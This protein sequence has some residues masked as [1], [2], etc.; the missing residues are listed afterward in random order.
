MEDD[1]AGVADERTD[2]GAD[3]GAARA[4]DGIQAAA[5]EV[6]E[7]GESGPHDGRRRQALLGGLWSATSQ[8][9]PAAGTAALS[10]VAAR[11]LGSDAL[12]TQS[13]IA[14]V[15]MATAAVLAA[16]LTSASLRTMG[17]LSGSGDRQRLGA[18]SRWA[19]GVH[20]AAGLVVGAIMATIGLV[21][22]RDQA[23][24]AVIGLVSVIDAAAMGVALP[25]VLRD[26]WATF[27]KL[28]LVFQLTAPPMGIAA[29]LLG[30]GITGIFVADGLAALGL[31][32]T[33]GIV[34]RGRRSPSRG[35]VVTGPTRVPS[36]GRVWGALRPPVPFAAT[37]FQFAMVELM[38]QVVS[39]R[40]EFVVLGWRSTS[41]Q[42]AM[43][44]VSFVVVGLLSVVPAAVAMAA[45]PLIAAAEGS[46]ALGAAARH[47]HVA[48]RLGTLVSLPLVAAVIALGP[49]TILLV[50]GDVYAEAAHLV[51]YAALALLA[52]VAS[53]VCTQFWLGQGKVRLV[54]W[55]GAA[56][57][58]IDIGLAIA[59]TP[60]MGAAGAVLANVVGQVSLA[61]LLLGVTVRRTGGFGWVPR[62]L[63][64]MVVVSAVAAA[65]ALL[66]VR[67]TT[68][69]GQQGSVATRLIA[70]VLAAILASLVGVGA[71]ALVKVLDPD[72]AD[73]L[74][75][76]LP[77]R[78]A[79]AVR[80][81]TRT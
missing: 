9:L 43:Y 3:P 44:S 38:V 27:G 48:V 70:L 76:L 34:L 7:V 73:W 32:V 21:L 57:G 62:N 12:G 49:T 71:A 5:V 75:P 55:C 29:V 77:R 19:T 81:V 46:G 80:A 11:Q 37:W 10:V 65:A 36:S 2:Q 53:G 26:G 20:V 28:S 63:A 18:M 56:A 47:L 1:D 13:L 45:M 54:L 17:R 31:L 24:W 78:L 22:H 52:T 41:E 79:T 74:R 15:N 23:S 68:S 39:R 33:L 8:L 35:P 64:A 30:G 72:E 6:A 66:V 42:I 58:V 67:L 25:V 51:P 69:T 61:A 4:T 40:V 16:S 50:Y 14:Y 60:S 59:A